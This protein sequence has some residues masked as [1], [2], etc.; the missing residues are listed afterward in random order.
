MAEYSTDKVHPHGY[1]PDYRRLAA[2]LPP[3]PAVCEVGVLRGESLVMWQDFFPGGTI[4]GV[5]CDEGA[6]WPAGTIAVISQQDDPGL[7]EAVSA[8]AP[9]GLDLIVDDA[10]HI[11]SL[12]LATF[13]LLW[14]LVKPGG[15]YVVEDWADPWMFP[16]WVRWPAVRPELAGDELIDKVPELITALNDGAQEVT[17]TREGLVIIRR[18]P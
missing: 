5:D 3:Q 13:A 11:G 1:L 6:T 9:G 7:A 16:D 10:S 14:P 18:R 17:Y 2:L 15:F 8:Y 12:T 4:I